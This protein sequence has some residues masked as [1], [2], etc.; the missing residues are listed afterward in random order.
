M[1]LDVYLFMFVSL[2]HRG[3]V[4]VKSM[5]TK[6]AKDLLRSNKISQKYQSKRS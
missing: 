3:D 2:S 5:F 4:F 1:L 6:C